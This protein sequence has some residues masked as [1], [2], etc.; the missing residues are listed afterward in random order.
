MRTKRPPAR[1]PITPGTVEVLG[2][3]WTNRTYAWAGLRFHE[4]V[5]RE[6]STLMLMLCGK[7]APPDHHLDVPF[8][9]PDDEP[10]EPADTVYRVRPRD[11]GYRFVKATNGAWVLEMQPSAAS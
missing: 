5:L 11:P 2:S 1:L 4:A 6:Q 10:S 7:D 9:H 8:C 3:R